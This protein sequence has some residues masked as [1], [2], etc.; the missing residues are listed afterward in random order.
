MT[1]RPRTG[2]RPRTALA[3]ASVLA[4]AAALTVRFYERYGNRTTGERDLWRG[5][6]PNVRM[7]REPKL[8]DKI[9]LR[10]D[11]R[12]RLGRAGLAVRLLDDSAGR[13]ADVYQLGT[14]PVAGGP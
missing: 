8:K 10:A 4:A 1:R 13:R 9:V 7:A 11:P 14:R 5:R 2:H 3:A 6:L 12:L